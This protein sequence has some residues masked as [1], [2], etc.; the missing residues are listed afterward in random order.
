VRMF[1][2]TSSPIDHSVPL[3]TDVKDDEKISKNQA[4]MEQVMKSL[5]K[6]K[7]SGNVR[8]RKPIRFA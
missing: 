4:V 6:V 8:Q 3:E 5:E 1:G 7:V 2:H